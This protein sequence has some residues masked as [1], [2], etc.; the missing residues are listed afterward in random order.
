MKNG[1]WLF[2][3]YVEDEIKQPSYIQGLF[4]KPLFLNPYYTPV[5]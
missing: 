3:V 1:P 2:R 4:H 5:I